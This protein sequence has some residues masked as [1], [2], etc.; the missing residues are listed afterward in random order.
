MRDECVRR[1]K[2]QRAWG[3][4]RAGWDQNLKVLTG[5]SKKGRLGR[6]KKGLWKHPSPDPWKPLGHEAVQIAALTDSR[7][8]PGRS[9]RESE[10]RLLCPRRMENQECGAL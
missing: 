1:P 3:S 8:R 4:G 9:E 6:M 7:L 10:A 5:T 2:D